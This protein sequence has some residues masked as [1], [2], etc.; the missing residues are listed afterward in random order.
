VKTNYSNR[1]IHDITRT[2]LLQLSVLSLLLLLL[3]RT[4]RCNNDSQNTEKKF[5]FGAD[6]SW[7]IGSSRNII[8]T[9]RFAF[10][11]AERRDRL[12]A[13]SDISRSGFTAVSGRSESPIASS[14]TLAHFSV[15]TSREC[16]T[17]LPRRSSGHSLPG[18][19]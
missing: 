14:A 4:I 12:S 13:H 8:R 7:K 3:Q 6:V 18:Y 5:S 2:K 9:S 11:G 19:Q 16:E 17:F 1:I 15:S 10:G